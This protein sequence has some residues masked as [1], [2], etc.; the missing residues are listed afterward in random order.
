MAWYVHTVF[1]RT[2][3]KGVLPKIPPPFPTKFLLSVLS[4]TSLVLQLLTLYS[5]AGYSGANEEAWP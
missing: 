5:L 1:R 4:G 2:L 3:S